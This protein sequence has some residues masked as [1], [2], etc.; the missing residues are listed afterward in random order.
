[1]PQ[2][3]QWIE[4]DLSEKPVPD[5]QTLFIGSTFLDRE[6]IILIDDNLEKCVCN[7]SGNC[8]FLETWTPLAVS[9]DFL[10]C[11]LTPWLLRLYTNYSRR[12]LK[13]FVNRNWIGVP[14]LAADS[15][16]FLHIANRMALSSKNV[17]AKYE[18]LGVPSL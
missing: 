14:P 12:Q 2:S 10:L 3:H 17:H 5:S 13:D 16:V 7:D 18:I 4:G 11:I 1:V 6:N 9:D 15:K 8:L